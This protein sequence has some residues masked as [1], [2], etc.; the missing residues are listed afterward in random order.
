MKTLSL[1]RH[2]K[3]S[4]KDPEL[5]DFDRPLNKRGKRDLPALSERTEQSGIR[6]DLILSSGA[7]RAITTAR[8][9]HSQ[10][11]LSPEQLL[12]VPEL[13]E[14]CAE[15]LLYILQQLPNRV[16][17]VMLV[18]HNPGLEIL[19]HLLTQQ[20]QEKFPTAAHMHMHLSITRWEELAAGCATLTLFD[21][22][23]KHLQP[24]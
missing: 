2:A 10:L 4:W 18:G 9:L 12:I 8:A 5:K 16:T 3:S 22:P 15:T 23:K 13:Y 11:N 17:H 14:A 20:E 19:G 24:A 6:P 1:V 21:Y 7:R